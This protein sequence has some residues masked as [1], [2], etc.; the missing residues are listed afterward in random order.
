MKKKLL[1]I[2]SLL[3]LLPA[4]ACSDWFDAPSDSETIPDHK[5][6]NDE[7]A[8]YNALVGVYT[9][10]RDADLYGENLTLGMLEY[11]GQ[12]MVP[13]DDET[14]S[15]S[16]YAY[17]SPAVQARVSTILREMYRSIAS[18]NKVI[19]EIETTDVV[20]YNTGQK[21]IITGELYALRAALHFD[22]VRLFHPAY[23]VNAS[24]V[25][26]PYETTFGTSV[27]APQTTTEI[28]DLIIQDMTYAATLLQ[29]YDPV[30]TGKGSYIASPGEIDSRTRTFYLNYYAVTALLA[31]I[32]MYKGDYTNAYIYADETFKHIRNLATNAQIFYYVS[33]G[34]YISD[35]C[36]SREHIWGI[37]SLPDGFTALS[38]TL[39]SSRKIRARADVAAIYPDVNDTRFREWFTR[40]SDA[41]Y[42]LQHKF[43]ASTLLTDYVTN[44]SGTA[45]D[46]PAR[47]PVI[48]MGE[49]ALI[50]AE[51]LNEQNNPT[52]AAEWLIEMQSS[53]RNSIVTEMKTAGQLTVENI[54]EAIRDEY[55]REFFG[56]GQLFYY[57]KRMN[58]KTITS[59]AGEEITMTADKYT[60]PIPTTTYREETE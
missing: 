31:R 26:L 52:E 35:F 39:F 32:Y 18:S 7:N 6:F 30:V 59:Y 11:M 55:H 54:R 15:M 20:F 21:E 46:L 42:T 41:S 33:P 24:F 48:K 29:K 27:G 19:D 3:L 60:F 28:L 57:H 53:K 4:V 45:T 2:L 25:G 23:S 47:I 51:S 58:D 17:A 56:E 12:N 22:L 5:Y 16:E 49:V 13:G 40:Q 36:F 44:T 14:R 43:G 8:F 50:A 38:D 9:Q 37:A 1:Y 34:K 10:L